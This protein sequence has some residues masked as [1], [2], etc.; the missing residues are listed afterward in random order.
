[1]VSVRAPGYLLLQLLSEYLELRQGSV[2]ED[3]KAGV[4]RMVGQIFETWDMRDPCG[5][6]GDM[7]SDGRGL[8]LRHEYWRRKSL[9][10]LDKSDAASL[11]VELNG[12]DIRL[13][14]LS[15]T[16]F[17]CG[18]RAGLSTLLNR[19]YKAEFSLLSQTT[20]ILLEDVIKALPQVTGKKLVYETQPAATSH[21]DTT[22]RP[23]WQGGALG[24]S[25]GGGHFFCEVSDERYPFVATVKDNNMLTLWLSTALGE[26]LHAT[27]FQVAGTGE[28]RRVQSCFHSSAATPS[29]DPLVGILAG[30]VLPPGSSSGEGEVETPS[31]E[32]EVKP[33]YAWH[34]EGVVVEIIGMY[35]H[36]CC[37]WR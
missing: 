23:V 37:F 15:A 26:L 29:R 1:M 35:M 36:G 12:T 30:C 32:A 5:I 31:K 11:Q 25:D 28:K 21:I 17:C 20:R 3:A 18:G 19:N 16:G 2:P 9:L 10:A 13:S 27:S 8:L 33:E 22:L 4:L 24:N 7:A 34:T 14:K 6:S